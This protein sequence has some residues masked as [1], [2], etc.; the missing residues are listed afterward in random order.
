VFFSHGLQRKLCT[1]E[2]VFYI[3]NVSNIVWFKNM[4]RQ[5][6]ATFFG[7]QVLQT[8][9]KWVFRCSSSLKPHSPVPEIGQIWQSQNKLPHTT[10]NIMP[11][12]K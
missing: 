12:L 8:S 1:L 4:K 2:N 7:L 9:K 11:A 5:K 10:Y 3:Q 6:N